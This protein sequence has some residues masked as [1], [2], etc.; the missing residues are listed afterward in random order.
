MQRLEK[1]KKNCLLFPV[2]NKRA[3]VQAT[4]KPYDVSV[5]QHQHREEK[6]GFSE[7]KEM[8]RFTLYL[9][10]DAAAQ[11]SMKTLSYDLRK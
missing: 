1:K 8:E 5:R 2:H 10:T 9:C 11:S 6:K 4:L 7:K 3:N